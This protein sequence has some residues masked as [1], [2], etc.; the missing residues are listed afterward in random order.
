MALSIELMQ[1]A[2]GLRSE[3]RR[4]VPRRRAPGETRRCGL[5]TGERWRGE[6]AA[7][8]SGEDWVVRLGDHRVPLRTVGEV[9]LPDIAFDVMMP[10]GDTPVTVVSDWRPGETL[11]TGVV[12][13]FPLTVQLRPA[14]AGRPAAV[15]RR[16]SSSR[17]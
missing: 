3:E 4:S 11:W 10:G 13:D 1:R 14:V 17:G 8:P 16:R 12:G 9:S 7:R 6:A 2:G 15:A 5:R